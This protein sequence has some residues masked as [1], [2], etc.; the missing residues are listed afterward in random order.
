MFQDVP[1]AP[2][3]LLHAQ[4]ARA[5]SVPLAH[6]RRAACGQRRQRRDRPGRVLRHRGQERLRQE[7]VAEDPRGDLRRRRGRGRGQRPAVAVHRARRRLQPGA[8]R[9]RER[10]DQRDHARPHAQAGARALR[11]DHRLR[12][13]RGLHR[14]Q[15]QELLVGHERATRLRGRDPGRRRHPARRRGARGRRRRLPAEVLRAVPGAQG[16]RAHDRLRHPRHVGGRALLR[17]RDAAGE[18]RARRARRPA[19]RRQGLQPAQLRAHRAPRRRGR[20]LRR[21][22]GRD[23]AR[24]VRGREL[25]APARAPLRRVLPRRRRGRSSTRTCSTR[26]SPGRCATTRGRPCS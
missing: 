5:A 6:L 15:A 2:S 10:P 24:L 16:R 23:R 12:R 14:P 3:E 19:P 9:A 22:L 20:A 8:D 26:C 4:G 25:Q 17:P 7:H 21:P 1:A 13:A 11:R 18:G